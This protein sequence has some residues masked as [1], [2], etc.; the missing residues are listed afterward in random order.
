[1]F[2]LFSKGCLSFCDGF[3]LIVFASNLFSLSFVFLTFERFTLGIGTYDE[4][5]FKRSSSIIRV[6]LTICCFLFSFWK[7]I[8]YS[9][10]FFSESRNRNHLD[11]LVNPE[12]AKRVNEWQDSCRKRK[13]ESP[14]LET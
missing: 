1:M 5:L 12:I 2:W 10:G 9:S 4:I 6:S 7:V 13:S 8:Y 3:L 11:F 14:D